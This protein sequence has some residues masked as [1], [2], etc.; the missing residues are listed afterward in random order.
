MTFPRR[1]VTFNG[2]T[3][4]ITGWSKRTGFSPSVIVKRLDAGWSIERTLTEPL[5]A[6]GRTKEPSLIPALRDY[7]R[8]LLLMQRQLSK[9]LAEF[10]RAQHRHNQRM[11]IEF[12]KQAEARLQKAAQLPP[13]VVE[14]LLKSDQHR[15]FP[16][17]QDRT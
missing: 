3:L 7:E 8:Q 17:A 13:G 12:G 6:R 4:T 5:S 11:A 14:D 2:E 15:A 1:L 9:S 10:I 16:V